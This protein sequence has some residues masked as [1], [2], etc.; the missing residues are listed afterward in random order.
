MLPGTC[1]C[2]P[3]NK[4][5]P[6][7]GA[8]LQSTVMERRQ[9]PAGAPDP[10][11]QRRAIQRDALPGQHLCLPVERQQ[12]CEPS[13]HDVRHQRD[14]YPQTSPP[15]AANLDSSGPHRKVALA[16]DYA[17]RCCSGRSRNASPASTVT[18]RAAQSHAEPRSRWVSWGGAWAGFT[19]HR[20][21]GAWPGGFGTTTMKPVP[22]TVETS[23]SS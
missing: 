16:P 23:A 21:G 14:A 3:W 4:P 6:P 9:P 22:R 1:P 18:G 17:G 10:I 2:D 15:I 7:R 20:R 12:V 5:R 13:D 8:W 19:A 11:G